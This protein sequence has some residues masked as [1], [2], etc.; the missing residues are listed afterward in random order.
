MARRKKSSPAEDLVELVSM[1][2]WW[3]GCVLALVSYLLLHGVATKGAVSSTQ[4]G[5]M[6]TQSLFMALASFGQYLLPLICQ[7]RSYGAACLQARR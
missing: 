3:A 1:M 5:T 4:L 2:P 7:R 6:M